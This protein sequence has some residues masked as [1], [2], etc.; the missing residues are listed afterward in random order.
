[1]IFVIVI[2]YFSNVDFRR[3]QSQE[4]DDEATLMQRTKGTVQLSLSLTTVSCST[5]SM[6]EWNLV[7]ICMVSLTI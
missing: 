4:P 7:T 2:I 1:M 3:S 6:Y 5:P